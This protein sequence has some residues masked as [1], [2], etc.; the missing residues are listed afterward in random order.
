MARIR[1]TILIVEDEILIRDVVAGEFT[2]AGYG[3][4]EAGGDAEAMA[5]LDG[6]APID[7]LFTDT[8][9]PGDLDGWAIARRARELRPLL[10]VFYA[11]GFTAD[12]PD[13]VAGGQFFRKPYLPLTIVAAARALGIASAN[14]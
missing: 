7:L 11:T 13:L 10:A 14:D 5:H 3:V 8:R 2:D 12:A 6:D 9:L 4:L 1:P